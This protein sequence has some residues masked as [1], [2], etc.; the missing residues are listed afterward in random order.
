MKQA[1]EDTRNRAI[2]AWKGGV[3]IN[4]VCRN[5]GI[6]RTTF[7]HWRMRD[8]AGE[9]QLPKPKGHNSRILTPYHLQ[10]ITLMMKENNSL[11]AWQI[12]EKLGIECDLG[13]IYRALAELGLTLK[14]RIKSK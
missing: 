6:C 7:Y 12:R 10:K 4:E 11:Y 14:K 9:P 3:S 8:A 2:A 13:V 1:S 5:F